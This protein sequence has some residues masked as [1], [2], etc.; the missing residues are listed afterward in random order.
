MKVLEFTSPDFMGETA[1]SSPRF[2]KTFA[3]LS[4][5]TGFCPATG[6]TVLGIEP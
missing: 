4:N 3:H 2:H 6:M 5:V 1:F